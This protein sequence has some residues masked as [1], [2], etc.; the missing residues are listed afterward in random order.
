MTTFAEMET[1]RQRTA[2][3]RRRR[4]IESMQENEMKTPDP[5]PARTAAN[6]CKADFER[7]RL[8]LEDDAVSERVGA[9]TRRVCFEVGYDHRS[10]PD[11]C[12]GGGHGQHG[13]TLRFVLIG[14]HGATQWVVH[15]PY[16]VPGNV[17]NLGNV[18]VTGHHHIDALYSVDLGYH[19]HA[20]QYED[21][22]SMECALLPGGECYYDGSGL[23]AGDLVGPFL[24]HG[25][26]AIWSALEHEYHVLDGQEP[27][28]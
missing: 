14:Q 3:L 27:Q 5:T 1:Q 15:L 21:Q 6:P 4:L 11:A 26:A 7:R 12:G 16:L 8:A 24:S 28:S 19:W 22:R 9:F 23:R 13:M 17:N 2:Q 18:P 25:P 20:P 10:H